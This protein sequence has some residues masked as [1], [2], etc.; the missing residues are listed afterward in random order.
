MW[1]DAAGSLVSDVVRCCGGWIV[2]IFQDV[3]QIRGMVES[4]H[5]TEENAACPS[6]RITE[7]YQHRITNGI[8]NLS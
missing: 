2:K 7:G 5:V 3:E 8:W 1:C 6:V 4:T